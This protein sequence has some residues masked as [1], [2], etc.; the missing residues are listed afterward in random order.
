MRFG[1]LEVWLGRLGGN[2]IDPESLW[3]RD[4]EVSGL[5]SVQLLFALLRK[6][7]GREGFRGQNPEAR[8]IQKREN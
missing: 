7:S 4:P 2:T 1:G 3:S 5:H 8:C 6:S